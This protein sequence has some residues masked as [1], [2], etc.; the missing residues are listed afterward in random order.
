M[1]KIELKNL[2]KS[3][4]GVVDVLKSIN[5]E[6]S[7]GEFTVLVGPSGCGKSTTLR[8]LA[9]L[10]D[11]TSGSIAVDGK[12]ITLT[13]PKDR[14]MAMVFQNYALYPH[15]SVAENIGFS[16][17]VSKTPKDEIYAR[18]REVADMLEI[19]ELLDRRPK[20]LSGG[21][22]QRVAIGRAVVK[23]SDIF[24]FD[25]PLS[26]LDAALRGG[27][28]VELSLLHQRLKKNMIYVTHD[29]V[30]AMTLGDKII[31]MHDGIIQQAGPPKE[32]FEKPANKFVAGFIGNPTMNFLPAEIV[33]EHGVQYAS[34]ANFMIKL[35]QGMETGR[36]IDPGTKIELGIRPE[37]ISFDDS[38]DL[39]VSVI[40][41]EYIG[42]QKNIIADL[43]GEKLTIVTGAD[44]D[45]DV[46]GTYRIKVN[47]SKL[48]LFDGESHH[49]I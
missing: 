27:M 15:M 40:V 25:E 13:A 48:H 33:E 22:R 36:K 43:G 31:I 16:L 19:G 1:P 44:T 24:L 42:N 9:G 23:D 49:S 4:D 37:D 38:G 3:Y 45:V 20:D 14:G 34:G 21:Q 11:A 47:A 46:G 17:K 5:L 8:L 2:T 10:E 7:D 12:D 26:N 18:V 32:I 6:M 28:R 39:N 29:Q 35:D 41:S 30:E